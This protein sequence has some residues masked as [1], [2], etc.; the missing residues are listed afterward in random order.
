MQLETARHV[1]MRELDADDA[2][3]LWEYSLAPV[4]REFDDRLP[5]SYEEFADLVADVISDKS[6]PARKHYWFCVV[7]PDDLVHPLGIV[8][9][10]VR[11]EVNRQAELGFM[12][13]VQYWKLGYTTDSIRRLLKFGY[14][15]LDL[16]RIYSKILSE[17]I[18]AR[19]ML[20]KLEF[21]REAHM[22]EAQRFKGRW[23]DTYIYAHLVSEWRG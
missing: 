17:N 13:G 10:I 8:Y 19:H 23:H 3:V 20:E 11:D 12:L 6:H 2:P 4:I 7:L 21:R 16:H 22:R 14:Q 15:E 1:L 18:H 5:D 9:L